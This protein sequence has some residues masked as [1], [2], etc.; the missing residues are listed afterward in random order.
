MADFRASVPIS[1]H[2]V[3][4]GVAYDLDAAAGATFTISNAAAASAFWAQYQPR[5]E[6]DD[7]VIWPTPSATPAGVLAPTTAT[8]GR[9]TS[10]GA[11]RVR[12]TPR[13]GA[14]SGTRTA[15][16]RSSQG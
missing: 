6:P 8:F 13:P 3:Y 11:A 14:A 15:C 1:I 16:W 5:T 2:Y 12:T 7:R 4:A 10:N 9:P